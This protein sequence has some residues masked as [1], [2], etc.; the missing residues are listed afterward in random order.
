MQKAGGRRQKAAM[1]KA[2]GKWNNR[3]GLGDRESPNP[4]GGCYKLQ[5]VCWKFQGYST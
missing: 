3:K 5:V 2:G 1:Q 4:C